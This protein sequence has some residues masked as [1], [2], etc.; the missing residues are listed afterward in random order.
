[1][2]AEDF[3]CSQGKQHDRFTGGKI[4][5]FAGAD[6]PNCMADFTAIFIQ[7]HFAKMFRKLAFAQTVLN[8]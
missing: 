7:T 3:L 5:D 4:S 6:S 8:F 1:M 2:R